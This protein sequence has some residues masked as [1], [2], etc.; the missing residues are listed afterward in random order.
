MILLKRI[1]PIKNANTIVKEP[2]IGEK[3]LP[4]ANSSIDGVFAESQ[5]GNHIQ[6]H[7]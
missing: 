4:A 7:S 3:N 6:D 1:F 5:Q 2:K